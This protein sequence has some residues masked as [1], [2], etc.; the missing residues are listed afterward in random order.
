MQEAVIRTEQVDLSSAQ[1]TAIDPLVYE[2]LPSEQQELLRTAINEGTYRKCPAADPYIPEP[3]SS[4]ARRASN[5]AAGHNT[6]YLKRNDVYYKLYVKI[7]DE[8]Y[9]N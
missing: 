6:A 2:N 1:R 9:V 5:H 8:V 4:F 7:E 3:L